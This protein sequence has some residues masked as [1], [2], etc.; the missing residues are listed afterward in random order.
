MPIFKLT[1]I[2][3]KNELWSKKHQRFFT[4]NALLLELYEGKGVI[5]CWRQNCKHM[6]EFDVKYQ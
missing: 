5:K 2:R 3:C 6:T 1:K 4:C